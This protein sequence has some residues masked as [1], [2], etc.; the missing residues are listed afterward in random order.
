MKGRERWCAD[1]SVGLWMLLFNSTFFE[2]RRLCHPNCDRSAIAVLSAACQGLCDSPRDMRSLHAQPL[3]T[4]SRPAVAGSAG[5]APAS[6]AAGAAG[7][8]AVAAAAAAAA[9]AAAATDTQQTAQQAAG[10]PATE[11]WEGEVLWKLPAALWDKH[12][13]FG[14]MQEE[15]DA[16]GK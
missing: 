15:I 3:C 14:L 8:A 10:L 6:P 11:P 1:V 7:G 16:P 2:D 9:D 13:I 12:Q 5:G 4:D